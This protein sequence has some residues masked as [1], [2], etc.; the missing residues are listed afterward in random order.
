MAEYD[1]MSFLKV[2]RTLKKVTFEKKSMNIKKNYMAF[3]YYLLSKLRLFGNYN[4]PTQKLK[5]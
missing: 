4:M 3:S 1:R 5:A 2:Q